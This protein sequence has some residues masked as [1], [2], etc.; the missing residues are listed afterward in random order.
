MLQPVYDLT[1]DLF[2]K[3]FTVSLVPATCD[4]TTDAE[5]SLHTG[6]LVKCIIPRLHPCHRVH[7]LEP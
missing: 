2:S 7:L 4:L 1:I 3:L 6:Q 5:N